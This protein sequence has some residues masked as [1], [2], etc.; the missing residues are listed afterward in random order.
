[1]LSADWREMNAYTIESSERRVPAVS[2][3]ST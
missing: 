2:P 3:C 1:M